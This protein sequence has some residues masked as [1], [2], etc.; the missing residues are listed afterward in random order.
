MRGR[1]N[2]KLMVN[3]KVSNRNNLRC[4]TNRPIQD[5][6]CW[7]AG[8]WIMGNLDGSWRYYGGATLKKTTGGDWGGAF[9]K[10]AV[11]VTDL[12]KGE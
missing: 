11:R 6:G 5:S 9:L 12:S 4:L 10:S 1:R 2:D 8:T 3:V 7:G